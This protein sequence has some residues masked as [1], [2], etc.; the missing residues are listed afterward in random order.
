MFISCEDFMSTN[1]LKMF[2]SHTIDIC[3]ILGK[4]IHKY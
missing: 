3:M 4:S 1:F 2:Q